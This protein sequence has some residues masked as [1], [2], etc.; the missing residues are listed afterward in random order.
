MSSFGAT[1]GNSKGF[2][3][4]GGDR[5]NDSFDRDS[6]DF[7]FNNNDISHDL[8]GGGYGSN[9]FNKTLKK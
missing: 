8:G 7:G 5:F 2:A 9:P 3:K 1:F 4:G 6:T